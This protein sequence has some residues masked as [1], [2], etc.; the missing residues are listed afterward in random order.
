MSI[1]YFKKIFCIIRI[2]IFGIVSVSITYCFKFYNL[3]HFGVISVGLSFSRLWA[4]LPVFSNFRLN[5]GHYKFYIL[6]TWFFS[7]IEE[8]W[9][10]A[11]SS[12]T[13]PTTKYMS[14]QT[15][16]SLLR[17]LYGSQ[18]IQTYCLKKPG[19][20]AYMC[21]P[22]CAGGGIW[23]DYDLK[24]ALTKVHETLYK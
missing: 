17:N 15:E 19:M 24:S 1:E 13:P 21:N 12:R 8:C 20:V 3:F 23:E 5:A 2:V 4:F 10:L 22:S 16:N 9:T 7:S 18:F 14:C 6:C 11:G